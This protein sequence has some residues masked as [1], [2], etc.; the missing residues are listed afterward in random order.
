MMLIVEPGRTAPVGS[1]TL[2]R[3]RPKLPWANSAREKSNTTTVV[4]SMHVVSLGLNVTDV[5]APPIPIRLRIRRSRSGD[6]SSA[7][8][9][10]GQKI[11]LWPPKL[12]LL[13]VHR[14]LFLYAWL[15]KSGEGCL[16]I[17]YRGYF[18]LKFGV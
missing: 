5:I 3:I 2:P 14:F 11:G 15:Y 9:S 13:S 12:Q 8:P 6:G 16:S 4:L 10:G 17:R 18:W 7:C 1:V